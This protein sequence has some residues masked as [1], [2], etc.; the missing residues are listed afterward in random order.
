MVNSTF[1]ILK[2]I[3]AMNYSLTT[4]RLKF[5]QINYLS[6]KL[7]NEQISKNY[8][9]LVDRKKTKFAEAIVPNK[10]FI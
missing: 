5:G 2:Q 8:M 9:L 4:H 6:P 7:K 1:L 3:L 10:S